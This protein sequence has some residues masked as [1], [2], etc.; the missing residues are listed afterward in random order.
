MQIQPTPHTF[1]RHTDGGLYYTI[2]VATSTVD[3]SDQVLYAHVYPFEQKMWVRPLSE[4]TEERFTPITP[5]EI[6]AIV[7]STDQ[8]EYQELV[9]A[10]KQKRKQAK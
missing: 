9:S 8:Q 5:T 1:Y 10:N 3:L 4:W 2:G 6:I 7:D